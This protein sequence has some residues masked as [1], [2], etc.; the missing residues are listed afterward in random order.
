[1]WPIRKIFPFSAAW[2]FAIVIPKRSRSVATTSVASTP[3]GARIAVTTAERS[4]SGEKSSRPIAFAPSR[5]PAGA[6]PPGPRGGGERPPGP[7]VK[8]EPERAVE[9]GQDRPGGR[10]RGVELACAL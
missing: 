9:G 6:G 1:M 10:E 4:S 8:G 7:L 5:P 2:P 3:S